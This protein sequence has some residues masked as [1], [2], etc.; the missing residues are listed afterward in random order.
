MTSSALAIVDNP[1]PVYS[2]V[3]V[4]AA[5]WL[6]ASGLIALTGFYRRKKV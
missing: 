6:F 4:P 2:A 5:I 1:F 3:P